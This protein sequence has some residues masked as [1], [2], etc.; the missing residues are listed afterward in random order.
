VGLELLSD[1]RFGELFGPSKSAEFIAQVGKY[2]L[3]FNFLYNKK[4]WL[5]YTL[6]HDKAAGIEEAFF[7][8]GPRAEKVVSKQVSTH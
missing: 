4:G 5:R 6:H 8:W 3:F 7:F 1:K 2:N